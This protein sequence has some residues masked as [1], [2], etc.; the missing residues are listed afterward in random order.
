MLLSSCEGNLS[1]TWSRNFPPWMEQLESSLSWFKEPVTE[2]CSKQHDSSQLSILLKAYQYCY[3]Q[4]AVSL[5]CFFLLGSSTKMYIFFIS[6]VLLDAV[7][8]SSLANGI[9]ITHFKLQSNSAMHGV[10]REHSYTNWGIHKKS[11]IESL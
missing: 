10:S 2:M 7:H 11:I 8:V 1:V 4:A 9:L 3:M 6:Y 5:R